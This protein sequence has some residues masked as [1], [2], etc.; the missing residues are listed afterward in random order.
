MTTTVPDVARRVT[1]TVK[2]SNGQPFNGSVRLLESTSAIVLTHQ[3]TRTDVRGDG[4]FVFASVPPG[5]YVVM[6]GDGSLSGRV[7]FGSAT[8]MVT[9]R[10]PPPTMVYTSPGTTLRGRLV[11]EGEA[12]A[13]PFSI[14]TQA[15][16]PHSLPV[17]TGRAPLSIEHGGEFAGLGLHGPTRFVI[18]APSPD[19]FL[20]SVTIDG[21]DVSDTG[22]DFG[23]LARDRRRGDRGVAARRV[24]RGRVASHPRPC[25][26]LNGPV[27]DTGPLL[28]APCRC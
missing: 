3:A 13:A 2:D 27:R 20:K 9:D 25:A 14:A 24:G 4:V 17:G 8:V 21:R 15:V 6:A 10:D 16:D 28:E 1:G 7:E 12:P 23:P 5:D 26:A 22:V 18:T 19:W 11:V